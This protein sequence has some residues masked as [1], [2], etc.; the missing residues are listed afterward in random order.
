MFF[1]Q[2]P[3]LLSRLVGPF[4]S[5]DMAWKWAHEVAPDRLWNIFQCILP[6]D[7]LMEG[8]RRG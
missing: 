2:D 3:I 8:P 7:Y 6:M 4:P 1:L 5:S